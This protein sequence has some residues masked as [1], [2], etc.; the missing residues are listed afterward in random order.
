[1][2]FDIGEKREQLTV[3]ILQERV[4]AVRG[5]VSH[6]KTAADPNVIPDVVKGTELL[7]QLEQQLAILE[8]SERRE[9]DRKRAAELRAK[10]DAK[11]IELANLYSETREAL[12]VVLTKVEAAFTLRKDLKQL[13]SFYSKLDNGEYLPVNQSLW[14]GVHDKLR[15]RFGSSIIHQSP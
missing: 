2:A 7:S 10:F 11:S 6:L 15:V 13:A 14:G 5:H 12:D 8:E 4:E 9:D 3:P 1:M